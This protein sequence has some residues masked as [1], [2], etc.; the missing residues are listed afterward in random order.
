M[1]SL[2][3]AAEFQRAKKHYDK[4]R[5][6]ELAAVLR[7]L[8]R[9]MEQLNTLPHCRAAQAGFLHHEPAGLWAIDQKG[10]SRVRLQETRLYVYPSAADTTLHIITLG[11]KNTQAADLR[12]ALAYVRSLEPPLLP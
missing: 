12:C 4:K 7:N 5:P 11:N 9:L 8:D 6:A 10:P 1:W 2:R 3:I